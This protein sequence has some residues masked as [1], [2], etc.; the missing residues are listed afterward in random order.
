VNKAVVWAVIG[1]VLIVVVVFVAKK[2]GDGDA[3][4]RSG[5]AGAGAASL[6]RPNLRGHRDYERVLKVLTEAA[7]DAWDRTWASYRNSYVYGKGRVVSAEAEADGWYVELDVEGGGLA[8]ADVGIEVPAA[9]VGGA[10]LPVVGEEYR[11]MGCVDAVTREGGG[12]FM[13]L[14]KGLV[15]K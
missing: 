2:G 10:S 15:G 5:A 14:Q 6:E 4:E 7:A 12:F 11:F 1:I 8:G 13:E 3:G 9:D